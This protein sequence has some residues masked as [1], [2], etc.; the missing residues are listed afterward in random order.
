[1]AD[2]ETVDETPA[3]PSTSTPAS[4][5]S[6]PGLDPGERTFAYTAELNSLL[7]RKKDL[8]PDWQVSPP[9]PDDSSGSTDDP[10]DKCMDDALSAID[11]SLKDA[12]SIDVEGPDLER[13]NVYIDSG[14]ST[15][16]SDDYAA[17][18]YAALAGDAV[19]ACLL[20]G[21][22]SSFTQMAGEEGFLVTEPSSEVVD[23]VVPAG[24]GTVLLFSLTLTSAETTL[25]VEFVMVL[26]GKGSILTYTTVVGIGTYDPSFLVTAVAKLVAR[27]EALAPGAAPLSR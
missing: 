6:L 13:E 7:I 12:E 9:K 23:Q 24:Y 22:K 2:V 11:A 14:A 1:M 10:L 5:E 4:A 26:V 17:A 21:V 16:W 15:F 18:A 20:E 3:A 19:R 25:P 8:G 27:V